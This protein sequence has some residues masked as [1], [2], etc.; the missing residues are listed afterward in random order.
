MASLLLCLTRPLNDLF[1]EPELQELQE[2]ES[3]IKPGAALC[4]WVGWISTLQ[5]SILN[6]S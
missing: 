2:Q 4:V 1:I 3:W 5:L 6:V